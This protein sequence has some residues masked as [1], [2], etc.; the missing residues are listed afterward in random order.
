MY[1]KRDWLLQG[2]REGFQIVDTK[3]I[4]EDIECANYKSLDEYKALVEGQVNFELD[5]GHYKVAS[6]KPRIVSAMGA[7]PKSDGKNVRLIHDCSRPP[8]GSVNSFALADKFKYQTLQDAVDMISP[9]CFLAKVD[10]SQAYRVVKTHPS[11]HIATGLKYKRTYL[12]DTRLPFGS[13]ASPYI[14][15]SL[16]QAVRAM[17]QRRGRNCICF[18]DDFLI[19]CSTYEECQEAMRQLITLL[20]KLG[21]WI[22]YS[23]VEGPAQ[24]LTF[25]GITLDTVAMTLSLPDN[26]LAELKLYLQKLKRQ[27]KVT[28]RS[29]QS[30]AG[31]LNWATQCIYGGRFHLRHIL[32]VIAKLK[33]P[34]HHTRVTREL[35]ADIDWWLAFMSIFNGSMDMVET[36]PATPVYIDSSSHAAGGYF[37]GDWIYAPWDRCW[38]SAAKHHINYKEVLALETATQRWAPLWQNKKIIIHTDNQAAVAIIRRGH[39]RDPLV[40]ASLRRIFWASAIYNFR[41]YPVY[42]PGRCN[43]LADKASRLHEPGNLQF[44][45]DH[46]MRYFLTNNS[47]PCLPFHQIPAL[48][49]SAPW[50]PMP[51]PSLAKLTPKP[52]RQPTGHTAGPI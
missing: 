20:R 45:I 11:N 31:R 51:R 2:I 44:L 18:L 52:P 25:L 24:S 38:P 43:V 17:M 35:H 14:F 21:F 26:K 34:W 28:K 41:L 40:S 47:H 39:A 9:G 13:S 12:V 32:D 50:T 33:K 16:T 6:T 42:L 46:S 30:L 4:V 19:I 49:W 23:K 7:I 29:L 1:P 37:S 10:L 48:P 3:D 27:H 15:N 8:A 22:N 36:R 5:H